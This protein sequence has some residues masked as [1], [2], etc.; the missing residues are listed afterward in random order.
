MCTSSTK[1]PNP[2]HNVVAPYVDAVS[3]IFTVPTPQS[4]GGKYMLATE[5]LGQPFVF[6]T[7]N[8]PQTTGVQ[9]VFEDL[10]PNNI[11]QNTLQSRVKPITPGGQKLYV[12]GDTPLFF[13][14]QGNRM[15]FSDTSQDGM[16]EMQN[17]SIEVELSASE[18]LEVTYQD[19]ENAYENLVPNGSF[20]Q[21]LWQQEVGDCNDYDDKPVLLMEQ[22]SEA[23]DGDKSLNLSAKAHIACTGSADIAIEPGAKYLVSFD[24]KTDGGRYAG[25]Y[26]GFDDIYESNKGARLD[27]SGGQWQSFNSVITAPDDVKSLRLKL[28]AYPDSTTG[29]TGTALYDNVQLIKIPD[30][31]DRFFLVGQ[32]VDPATR[33]PRVDYQKSDPTR[34]VVQI[35]GAYDP[36]FLTTKESY[37][38]LWQLKTAND[39]IVPGHLKIND[40][41]NG[42]WLQPK[43]LC[44]EASACTQNADGSYDM[45]LIMSFA[46]QQWFYKGLVI[47][48]ITLLGVLG[49]VGFDIWRA[50]QRR[51]R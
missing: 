24:Y 44:Q 7:D 28:Y 26:A 25:Y 6:V 34:V 38:H 11:D 40:S 15:T 22:S 46:P 1:T 10:S 14:K 50:R 33:A 3:T 41:M 49:Y 2:H 9:D 39:T 12:R 43:T 23:T 37:H 18:E 47:S 5:T 35:R 16:E 4:L 30:V 42:W 31:L 51:T 32:Q 29:Q 19:Q 36:F 27:D 45:T 17:E 8:L 48:G 20:E 21:G 13:E